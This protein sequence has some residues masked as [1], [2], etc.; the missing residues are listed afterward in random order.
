MI[1][2]IAA[3]LALPDTETCLATLHQLAPYIGLAEICLDLMH[4]FDLPRLIGAAPCPLI[5]TC[6]PQREGGSFGG[7]E[8]E[9]LQILSQAIELGCDYVD[10]EWDSASQLQH[11]RQSPARFIVSC[12][13]Y[14]GIPDHLWE[15]YQQLQELGDVVKLVGMATHL[16]DILPIVALM[17]R[18]TSPV[19]AI[20]MGEK[21]Q[22]TRLLSPC[23]ASCLLTYAAPSA[24][25]STA[26]GQLSIDEMI[27]LYGLQT[28]G[29]DTS[30][31]L[32]ICPDATTADTLPP[33]RA[34][35]DVQSGLYIPVTASSQ[36]EY[37]TIYRLKSYLPHLTITID[38]RLD[39]EFG[40]EEVLRKTIW[41]N[42]REER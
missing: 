2:K 10:I 40:Y 12:H 18:A 42:E 16:A 39:K 22:L 38:P 7:T 32:H 1:N 25:N 14:D 4:S 31:H 17:H 13:Q 19:I 11:Y 27:F 8:N 3:S 34:I 6:R 23:F 5:I 9:R 21:G 37:I 36:N 35:T 15:R 20:A 33:K 29:P 30:V 26:P 28:A 41:T 24:A